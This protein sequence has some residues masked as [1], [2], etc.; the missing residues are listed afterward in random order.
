MLNFFRGDASRSLLSDGDLEKLHRDP[1]TTRPM[2]VVEPKWR[3]G[4]AQMQT[5]KYASK[6]KLI[7][8]LLTNILL[9]CV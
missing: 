7:L 9:K 6:N 8:K 3:A 5:S 1:A 4:E 2:I